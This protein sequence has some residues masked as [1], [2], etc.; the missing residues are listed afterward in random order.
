MQNHIGRLTFSPSDLTNFLASPL[1]TWMDRYDLENPGVAEPDE[2]SETESILATMGM[3]H[4]R[5]YL[6]SLQAEGRDICDLS[7]LPRSE[8]RFEATVHA[9]KDGR[10][11][12]YQAALKMAV[13]DAQFV[14]YADFL[15]KTAGGPTSGSGLGDYHYEPW[16]TKLARNEKPKALVQLACYADM[17]AE[18]QKVVPKH[19]HLVLGN[20]EHKA[21]RTEDYIYY[22][23]QLQKALLEQQRSWDTT[24]PPDFVGLEKFGRWT[25]YAQ[26]KMEKQDHLCRVANIRSIQIKKLNDAG[27]TTMTQ[28][29]NSS[30]DRVAKMEQSTFATLKQQARLQIE[31][32][33]LPK[34]KYEVLEGKGLAALPPPSPLDVYFDME[35]YPLIVGGLEYLFGATVLDTAKANDAGDGGTTVFHDW[36]AHDQLQERR[37]FEAFIDWVYARWQKDPAMHIYHYAAYEKSALRRLMSKYATRE[38][39]VDELLRH[40]VMVDLFSIVRQSIRVGE[41]NYSIKSIEHLYKGKRAG[42]VATAMESVVGYQRWLA[43]KDGDDW[44]SSKVLGDIR[45]YNKEDCD[46][47]WQLAQW[48]RGL[49]KAHGIEWRPK[50]VSTSDDPSPGAV[51]RADLAQLVASMLA[52]ISADAAQKTEEM[53]L[54]EL[55]GFLL[56]FHWREASV[57]GYV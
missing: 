25:T 37:A 15:I 38:T 4:E 6:A 20:K 19:V 12:I 44:Q 33:G 5:E 45:A 9:M 48:L 49:Q 21:F 13:E 47:T 54:Q 27:I 41:P 32:H 43:Q 42:D 17:L 51:L 40:E 2:A 10:E 3:E 53:R 55:L 22:Y 52:G 34:P 46:S 31:S 7:K 16:D 56:E 50:E 8:D 23:R 14:G 35:G 28:L 1:V 36:W 39:E 29:A 18:I 26:E 11:V 57:L 30:L 24:K